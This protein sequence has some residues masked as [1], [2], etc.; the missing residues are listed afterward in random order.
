MP[1]QTSEY[2]QAY[3]RA[4][5]KY[6]GIVF[7]IFRIVRYRD[8]SYLKNFYNFH[9]YKDILI[10]PVPI[11]RYAKNAIHS[12]LPGIITALLYHCYVK[13]GRAIDVTRAINN[14]QLKLE[15]LMEDILSIYECDNQDSKLYK[16]TIINEVTNVFNAFKANTNSEIRIPD[17]IKSVNARHKGPM[18]NLRDVDVPLEVALKGN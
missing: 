2:I 10:N 8:K 6:P 15:I 5:R 18:T 4:G 7:D 11:N 17:L 13:K 12:T 3:S 16:E 14:G 9:E 1:T